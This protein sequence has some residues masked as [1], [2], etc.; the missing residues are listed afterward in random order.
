MNT[1]R[2]RLN[3]HFKRFQRLPDWP[4][5]EVNRNGEAQRAEKIGN[6]QVRA[7]HTF[8]TMRKRRFDVTPRKI[9]PL[10]LPDAFRSFE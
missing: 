7:I 8:A 3:D 6:S 9:E 5:P 10:D 2:K 1:T 4:N